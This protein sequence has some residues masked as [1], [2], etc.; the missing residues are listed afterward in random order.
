M[1]ARGKR[2]S[3]PPEESALCIISRFASSSRETR[4]EWKRKIP[5]VYDWSA[6]R[7][8]QSSRDRR[9]F[10]AKTASIFVWNSSDFRE[11]SFV[12]I[13]YVFNLIF[14]LLQLVLYSEDSFVIVSRLCWTLLIGICCFFSLMNLTVGGT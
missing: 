4:C 10:G 5:M 7:K 12:A 3:L 13:T 2:L 8:D 11:I 14:K 9:E 6:L 1:T